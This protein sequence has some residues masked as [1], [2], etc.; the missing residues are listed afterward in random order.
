M[1]V[2]FAWCPCCGHHHPIITNTPPSL[3]AISTL[4]QC[5]GMQHSWQVSS[6]WKMLQLKVG[7]LKLEVEFIEICSQTCRRCCRNC[8]FSGTIML[9][10]QV[11]RIHLPYS[12]EHLVGKGTQQLLV[13]TRS[14]TNGV[15]LACAALTARRGVWPTRCGLTETNTCLYTRK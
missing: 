11:W 15:A 10:I 13:D 5:S 3:L 2:P 1:A 12:I 6:M 14:C 4:G 9:E 8:C 7:R